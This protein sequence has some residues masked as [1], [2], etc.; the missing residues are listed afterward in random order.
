MDD[1]EFNKKYTELLDEIINYGGLIAITPELEPVFEEMTKRKSNLQEDIEKRKIE[2]N[3][4]KYKR[5]EENQEEYETLKKSY[6][7]AVDRNVMRLMTS[8]D[9]FL[10]IPVEDEINE[11]ATKLAYYEDRHDI[12]SELKARC[13]EVK[14]RMDEI[15]VS[16]TEEQKKKMEAAESALIYDRIVRENDANALDVNSR[17]DQA[18][19]DMFK[20]NATDARKKMKE[21]QEKGKGAITMQDIMKAAIKGK[22]I[23]DLEVSSE[24]NGMNMNNKAM[25]EQSK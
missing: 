4:L 9:K 23:D 14:A 2:L 7:D 20:R 8:K 13:V 22:E 17:G 21:S 6:A 24:E 12:F 19:S 16:L 15:I 10:S 1:Q 25:D 5:R 11:L 3:E 18:Y